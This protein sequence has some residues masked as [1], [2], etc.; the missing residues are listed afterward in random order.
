MSVTEAEAV[1]AT[2]CA[3]DML[4]GMRILESMGLK[5]K[6][7]MV[8][9]VDNK[10]AVDIFNNWSVGGRTRHI[11]VRF[12]FMRELKEEG[13]IVVNWIGTDEN[14]SDLFTKNLDGPTFEK[15]TKTYCGADKYN[16]KV[17]DG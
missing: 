7:P 8:L 17:K 12:N 16:K 11:S 9:E 15:H 10:G 4:F 3:Q 5:V 2:A 6:K 1:A 14:S 13:V